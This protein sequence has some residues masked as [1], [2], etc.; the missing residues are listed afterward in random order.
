MRE[1]KRTKI[2]KMAIKEK[3]FSV[4]KRFFK[5]MNVSKDKPFGLK[6]IQLI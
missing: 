4:P 2:I 5:T 1:V 3:T 6:Y